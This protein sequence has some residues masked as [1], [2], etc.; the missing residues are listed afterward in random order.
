MKILYFVNA[1]WYFELHWID[2]A[3][4]LQAEGYEIHLAS[5]FN[6]KKIKEKIET[7]GF[8]CWQLDVDRFSINP[9]SN[10]KNLLAFYK[11]QKK[12][13]PCLVHLITIKAVVLGGLMSRFYDIPTVI[14][15]VGLGRVFQSY[16][17]VRIIIEKL[18]RFIFEK[19]EKIH[20]I[21]EH[22][23]DMKVLKKLCKLKEENIH[24]INGAGVDTEKF[25]YS[26]E[27]QTER[28]EI[29]FAS[30]L[31]KSKGLEILVESVSR[32]KELNINVVLNVAGIIDEI[33]PDSIELEIIELWD[34][35][36]KINWLGRRN[37]IEVLL[38]ECN[39]M[40]LPTRYAEGI[41]RIV[42]EACSVGRA[43]V[44][45]NMPGCHVVIDDLKNGIILHEHTADELTKS[46]LFLIKNPAV[47]INY[48][49]KSS[50]LICKGYSKEIIISETLKVYQKLFVSKK[51]CE[52]VKC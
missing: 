42:L 21:F 28:V 27:K 29:L 50:E 22:N 23:N 18:Y 33:D 36:G 40:A 14:S 30:R 47:R 9:F 20:I 39:I 11:I 5:D 7:L 49:K 38:K 46:L 19:N 32:L 43:C 6:D 24:V 16:G 25:K 17:F 34:R 10:I 52:K 1:A 2:R 44:V 3:L 15:I 45:G 48:G 12:I 31:L 13:K 35:Q 26:E 8:I 51:K 41:P 4:S 37:D